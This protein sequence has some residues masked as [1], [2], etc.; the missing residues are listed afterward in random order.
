MNPHREFL[1]L[2]EL[3]FL[4]D[5]ALRHVEAIERIAAEWIGAQNVATS[6][7]ADPHA[8]RTGPEER[9]VDRDRF[10]QAMAVLGRTQGEFFVHLEAL[11]AVFGRLSLTLFPQ[12][13][14]EYPQRQ[15]RAQQLRDALQMET[16]HSLR[17]RLFRNKWLHHDEVLD[18]LPESFQHAQRFTTRKRVS[19]SDRQTVIRLCLIDE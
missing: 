14:K 7:A 17:H 12:G 13:E 16:A 18:N 2:S 6:Y 3:R 1:F 4:C 15:A 5:A 8:R 11:R 10:H 19:D 9:K